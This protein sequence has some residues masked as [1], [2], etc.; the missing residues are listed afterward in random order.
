MILEIAVLLLC[1]LLIFVFALESRDGI[2]TGIMI[3]VMDILYV[4]FSGMRC[5][6][7]KNRTNFI[8]KNV[9]KVT[10]WSAVSPEQY[11][12][13]GCKNIPWLIYKLFPIASELIEDI[14]Q[15]A[16]EKANLSY[17]IYVIVVLDFLMIV[18][19]VSSTIAQGIHYR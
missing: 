11:N 18:L 4:I 17:L 14:G 6:I 12:T 19:L 1:N 3:G 8:F 2:I 15:V 16:L 13:E 7:K 10:E 9:R 5:C